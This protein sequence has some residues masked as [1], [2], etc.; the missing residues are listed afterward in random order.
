VLTTTDTAIGEEFSNAIGHSYADRR[1]GALVLDEVHEILASKTFRPCMQKMWG[2][3]K[4]IYPI[5]GMSG[6]I[7]VNMEPRLLA[8]LGLKPDTPVVRQ[9]SNRP[10]LTYIIESPLTKLDDLTTRIRNIAQDHIIQP[11]DRA[12]VFVTTIM[13]GELIAGS[14]GCE[15]YCADTSVYV[16]KGNRRLMD[17]STRHRMAAERRK[18][19]IDNWQTGR[20]RIMV[21]TTAF[22]AGN[23]YPGVRVVILAN[24]PFDMASIVQ[25]FGRAGRDGNQASCYIIPSKRLLYRP[26]EQSVDFCGHSAATEMIWDSMK[27]I[28]F[29]LTK[30]VDGREATCCLEDTKN[31]ICS[32]CQ[33]RV[34]GEM[35]TLAPAHRK[36]S[37]TILVPPSSSIVDVV[38][39]VS[40]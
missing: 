6:T 13:N 7:P 28:R 27:C 38:S 18:G 22:G 30:Y 25:Q 2:V 10:E 19:I 29:L 40:L 36:P 1:L 15:F 8:E 12:L 3:R 37:G 31:T 33:S 24:T 32:R 16:S 14:L 20:Y 34:H 23:D 5:I 35:K 39:S 17:E 26:G 4:L 9:S 11:S 21:A